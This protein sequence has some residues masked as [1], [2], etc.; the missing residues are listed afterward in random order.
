MNIFVVV[1]S[2][3]GAEVVEATEVVESPAALLFRQGGKERKRFA[4]QEVLAWQACQTPTEAIAFI[5]DK[6]P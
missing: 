4:R 2:S 6:G 5:A 1:T 3:N